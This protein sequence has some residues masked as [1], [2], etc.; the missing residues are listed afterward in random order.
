MQASEPEPDGTIHVE[1]PVGKTGISTFT[2]PALPDREIS[3]RAVFA[4]GSPEEFDVEP[5][6]GVIKPGGR[7]QEVRVAFMP[8]EYAGKPLIGK[9]YIH[10]SSVICIGK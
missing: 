9:L 10:V 4:Q 2:I 5:T 6:R 3:Y 1:A 7:G 8:R